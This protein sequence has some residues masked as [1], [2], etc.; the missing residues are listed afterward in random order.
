MK[1]CRNFTRGSP[2][3][4]QKSAAPM[5]L[6]SPRPM[7]PPMRAPSRSV[8]SADLMRVSIQ[9]AN[10]P[11]AAPAARLASSEGWKGRVR[12]AA[13]ATASTNSARTRRNQAI[14]LFYRPLLASPKGGAR[15][16]VRWSMSVLLDGEFPGVKLGVDLD[17]TESDV[18]EDGTAD[19]LFETPRPVEPSL[20]PIFREHPSALDEF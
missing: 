11:S 6:A 18:F 5:V 8:T 17:P 12:N 2:S 14:A 15:R 16:R 13:Y 7:A 9:M 3:S 4:A 20:L 19:Q 10:T 1:L